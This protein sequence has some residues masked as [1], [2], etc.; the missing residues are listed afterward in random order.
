[1]LESGIEARLKERVKQIG[2]RCVK[3]ISPGW[4]GVPD[5]IVLM[6]E[7]RIVFAELKQAGKKER[8][9]QKRRQ[10]QLREMGFTVYETVD[11]YE[12]IE[13]IIEDL[14]REE[15]SK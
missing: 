11:S 15:V 6:P 9:L 5:R 4:S 10:A 13:Q 8:P 14:Q 2:G 7:G 12:K 1:M 3:W